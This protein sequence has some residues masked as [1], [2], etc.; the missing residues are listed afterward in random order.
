MKKI[1]LVLCAVLMVA[2][3][4]LALGQ[5]EG[6]FVY[7]DD[8]RRDPF[9]PLVDDDGRFI[10]EVGELYSFDDLTLVGI[11]WDRDGKSTALIND[12]IVEE[13][14]SFYGFTIKKISVNSVTVSRDGKEYILWSTIAE[15][16]Q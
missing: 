10:M 12:E 11:L 2:G 16:G 4:S 1:I 6:A 15:E 7:N 8:G 14:Q 5:S 13:G 3:G 9:V